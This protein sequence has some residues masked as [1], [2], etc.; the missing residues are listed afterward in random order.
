ME[1]RIKAAMKWRKVTYLQ[2]L[3]DVAISCEEFVLFVRQKS[4]DYG[5][6]IRQWPERCGTV[7][8]KVPVLT[9]FGTCFTTSPDYSHV[10]SSVGVTER[11][12]LLLSTQVSIV[13]RPEWLQDEALRTGVQFSLAM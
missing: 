1:E 12:T 6:N 10:T 9:P 3:R 2:L 5:N 13:K 7:Y 11:M 4:D 8:S